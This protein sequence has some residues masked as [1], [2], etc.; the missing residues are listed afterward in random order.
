MVVLSSTAVGIHGRDSFAGVRG[1]LTIGAFLLSAT[2]LAQPSATFQ[3]LLPELAEKI[4][5]TIAAG[6]RASLAPASDEASLRDVEREVARLLTS[7][8]IR[9]AA[10]G[11]ASGAAVITVS[12]G[13][14]LRERACVAD[15]RRGDTRDVVTATKAHA[16]RPARDGDASR[17]VA[18]EATPLFAQRA[19]MLD[20]LT[21][22]DRLLVLDTTRITLYR[23]MS[24]EWQRVE[25]RAIDP[26]RTWPRDV[27]GRLHIAGPALE[28]FLPGVVC[29]TTPE[30]TN[31]SCADQREPW[32]LAVE[33]AGLDALRNTF[34]TPEG[35]PF[36]SAA[37]LNPET[38][39]RAVIVDLT[40]TLVLL[41]E[42]RAAVGTIG[43]ADDVASLA[44]GCRAGAYLLASNGTPGARTDT[45][46]L[47]RV[48]SR[49][50]V[51]AATPVVLP[52]RVT[53]LWSEPGARV[54]TAI[55]RDT[56]GDRHAAFQI[57]LS[58]PL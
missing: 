17:S 27:R 3:D 53:A 48:E 35:T 58:C 10:A 50:A 32:P 55:V 20:L 57:R 46:Q 54:A 5:T 51:P 1:L 31:F 11:P 2:A 26:S 15:I 12:C 29:R 24:D 25:S 7:R 36:F 30:L 4:A 28:A 9:L 56:D 33:N 34:Q 18:I 44:A 16:V 43:T 38:G 39:A 14:N 8:G 45:L 37:A 47:L 49:T 52:G 6:T 13:E 22:D 42:S 40:H 41:N 21:I 19:P 23:R